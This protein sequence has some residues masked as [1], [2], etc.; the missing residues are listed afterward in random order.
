MK[1]VEESRV[2]QAAIAARDA[3]ARVVRAAARAVQVFV[4]APRRDEH[5]PDD[6]RIAPLVASA[7]IVKRADAG[8]SALWF[9]WRQSR[10][11][12]AVA[13]IA[14]GMLA[15]DLAGRLQLAGIALSSALLTTAVLS[16]SAGAAWLSLR[17]LVWAA[18]LVAA[19]VLV[20]QPA[21]VAAAWT[22]RRR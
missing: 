20:A 7:Q 3:A 18:A 17:G 11:R 16:V 21:A 8:A 1:V 22:D 9:A 10:L 5:E 4:A 19:L 14:A 15:L 13:P 6:Q 2:F 12:S